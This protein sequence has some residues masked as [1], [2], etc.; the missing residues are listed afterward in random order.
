MVCGAL[1]GLAFLTKTLDAFIVVPAFAATY[2]WCGRPRLRRRI[3]QLAWAGLALVVSSSWWIAIVELWPAGSRPYLGG[4]TDNSELNLIFG[5]NGFA[6]I[7]GSSGGG[8][9]PGGGARAPRAP[10]AAARASS[11]CSTAPW[12]ARS[13][14]SSRSAWPGW[15]PGCGSPG[16]DPRT[17]L[18]R[19][20]FV[21]FGGWLVVMMA[22][23]DDAKGI[24]H[25]YYTA[26][27][28]PA[29][30][31]LAGAGAVALWRLGRGSRAWAWALPAAVVGSAVWADVL[32]GRTAGL[33]AVARDHRGGGGGGGRRRAAGRAPG[34]GAVRA[35]WRWRPG[36]WR[37]WPCWPVP[38]PT[39]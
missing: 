35:S 9:A 30:A 27:M 24:F 21:L 23:Y 36:R 37:R 6:R 34:R 14:G 2:L 18:Q 28:A 38:P 5:Y 39:P 19:A 33:R 12:A 11:G 25:P 3:G 32:L 29:V 16:A 17:G 10:S 1:L 8:G 15:P 20:G 4:S 26:V 13:P 31:A 7:F 22:V